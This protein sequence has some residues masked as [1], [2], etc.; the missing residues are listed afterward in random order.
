[1]ELVVV[2][3]CLVLGVVVGFNLV[4]YLVLPV[5]FLLFLLV[6]MRPALVFQKAI[7][8]RTTATLTAGGLTTAQANA[9]SPYL[10]M[11]FMQDEETLAEVQMPTA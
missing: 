8:S 7:R 2:A 1:M 5:V 4:H 3:L 11:S 6:V 10:V 9:I